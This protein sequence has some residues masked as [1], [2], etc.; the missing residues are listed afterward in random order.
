MRYLLSFFI[1]CSFLISFAQDPIADKM[2][3]YGKSKSA[4]NL[5]VHFDKNIYANNETVWFTG[6]LLN[7]DSAS[8]SKH[9]LLALAL[10]RDVDSAVVLEDKFL[11]QGGISFGN[12][13]LPDSIMTGNYHFIAYT[14]RILNGNPEAVFIQPITLK[15]SIDPF[16]KA[17]MKLVDYN[18]TD[19]LP[20]KVML[21]VT[22]KDNRF[23][24]KPTTVTYRY[25]K[26][27]QTTNTDASGQLLMVLPEQKN[28]KDPNVYVKLK[29]AKDSSFISM[30]IPQTKNRASVKFYPEGGNMVAGIATMVGWEVKDQQQMP[31]SLKAFLYRNGVPMDTIE[32]GSYGIGKFKIYPEADVIYT[33]KLLHSALADSTYTLPKALTNGLIINIP[34]SIAQDTLKVNLKSNGPKKIQIRIHNFRECFLSTQFEM[35]LQTR[36]VKIPLTEIPK[37]LNTITITDSLERPLAEKMFFAH[38]DQKEP[39]SI[40]ADKDIYGQREKVTLKLK[41]NEINDQ[42]LVSI[43]CVQ[44]NRLDLKNTIDIVNYTYL[45]NE[46]NQLPINFKGNSLADQAYL[47]T[48]LLVKGWR[49]YTWQELEETKIENMK[50]DTASL[51][52]DGFVKHIRKPITMPIT[53]V[54]MGSKSLKWINTQIDGS[55]LLANE[56]LI[57]D[58]GTKLYLLINKKDKENYQIKINDSYFNMSNKLAKTFD[59]DAVILPSTLQNNEALVLKSNEREIRLKEVVISGNGLSS[60]FNFTANECGDYVCVYNILNCENHRGSLGNKPPLKGKIYQSQA[61]S[62]VYQGCVSVDQKLFFK[63]PAIHLNKEFYNNDYKDPMEPAYFSTIYWNFGMA[64]NG[65]NE[66]EISFYTSDIVGKF[67]VVVQG[68]SNNDVI[69]AEKFF[70]V[71]K[72]N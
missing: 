57:T 72:I 32:T 52:M 11:V 9:E 6:Y 68:V 38:Y 70:E 36:V 12:F 3:W 24:P 2:S 64:L 27:Q 15:T 35:D 10:I 56:N 22:S 43:A 1:S 46:L 17:S 55:F 13:T 61:G 53:L 21:A 34:Q 69:Y 58:A 51:K 16:F 25:G 7:L 5:F 29:Y 26:F 8:T 28:L 33:V 20:R 65:K 39:I 49:R 71:K 54:T 30:A 59:P 63:V 23:L 66:T 44:D 41:L 31:I 62:V 18:K 14:N 4:P 48:I 19:N 37:G 40:A 47:E 60:K 67:R 45:K 42:A 50:S